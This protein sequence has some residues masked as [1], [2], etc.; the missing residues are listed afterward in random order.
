MRQLDFLSPRLRPQSIGKRIKQK[1]NRKQLDFGKIEINNYSK[2]AWLE[3][4]GYFEIL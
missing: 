3:K 2:M 1:Y 4:V